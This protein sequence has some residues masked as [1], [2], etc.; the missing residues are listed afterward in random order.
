MQLYQVSGQR[1]SEP[2][3][4]VVA[5]AGAVCLF[6][7]IENTLQVLLPDTDSAVFD[8]DPHEPIGG[9]GEQAHFS[10]VRSELGGIGDG[11]PQLAPAGR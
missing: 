2:R 11:D 1:E 10:T 4:L 3:A 7:R 8:R 9:F 5:A 6:E